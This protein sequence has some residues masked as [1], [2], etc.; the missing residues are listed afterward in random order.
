ME[1]RAR[2]PHPGDA[3]EL[4]ATTMRALGYAIVDLVVE[5]IA[6]LE[7]QPVWVPS[8]R[9]ELEARVREPVPET[10]QAIEQILGQLTTD[11]LPYAQR[12]DHARFFAYIPGSPTW[13]SILGDFVAGG[14]NL[15][16]G[17]WYG[18]AGP[19][20]V[21]LVVLDWF[22]S[23]LGYPKE[24]E[25]LLVSGGSEA[26]LTAL[27]CARITLL[28]ERF[29]D[30]V[31][32]VS[33]QVHSSVERAARILGFRTDQLRAVPTDVRYRIDPGALGE[34]VDEDLRAGHRPFFVAANAG[35][36]NTGVVDPLP[37]LAEIC[38]ARDLW[39]HVDG[40][41]GGFAALSERGRHWLSG[42]ELADSIT[43]DP[44]K[45]LFQP[46]G[47]GC[48]LVRDGS[49]LVES[50]HV[51]PDYLQ[52]ATVRGEEVNFAD[53]GLQLTRPARA[54]KIWLSLKFFGA[55][56]FRRAIDNGID[57][58]LFAQERIE[59]SPT[60]ELLT[61]ASLGIVCFRRLGAAVASETE[62]EHLNERLVAALAASG[63][64]LV[65]S[66]RLQGRYCLRLCVLNFRS[67][68]ED[69]ER[70]LSWL[71]SAHL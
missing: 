70:V 56:A 14:F 11:V 65:S 44:H 51:M 49:R 39:L 45:W 32:Y 40:A 69:V 46:W 53:R 33:S 48:L 28:G 5:R 71:E 66:T 8:T 20:M 61:P 12:T 58:A 60:L 36:T 42:I 41:Y 19:S 7:E 17:T 18:G 64:G 63:V 15:F 34:A 1:E 35:A 68:E 38:A 22:K 26:N 31:V 24:A 59:R 4:D 16:Q 57:L 25:G 29:D 10:P 6:G 2:T 37:E 13:P 23:W 62:L 3:L 43:L 55:A 30:A 21:E 47:T 27:A 52:D 9:A 50:F 54:L 67:G